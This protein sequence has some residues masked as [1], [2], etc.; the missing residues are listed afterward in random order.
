MRLSSF[1]PT[2]ANNFSGR[3]AT[4]EADWAPIEKS[5][6]SLSPSSIP[7]WRDDRQAGRQA[8]VS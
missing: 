1:V 8:W 4:F 3:E 2:Q 5:L 6:S 7:W